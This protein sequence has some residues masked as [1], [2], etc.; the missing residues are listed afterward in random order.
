MH[1]YSHSNNK[2]LCSKAVSPKMEKSEGSNAKHL[3]PPKNLMSLVHCKKLVFNFWVLVGMNATTVPSSFIRDQWMQKVKT[4]YYSS[5]Y[6][7][8]KTNR[9]G[10]K[11]SNLSKVKNFT[12][13]WTRLKFPLDSL[14]NN[15]LSRCLKAR[16]TRWSLIIRI[17]RKHVKAADKASKNIV[18]VLPWTQ[19]WSVT[20]VD[21]TYKGRKNISFQLKA[22]VFFKGTSP[23]IQW[24]VDWRILSSWQCW[25]MWCRTQ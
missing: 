15:K 12:R 2:T 3:E 14:L 16:F 23:A 25:R 6:I 18:V 22:A 1:M 17:L 20:K 13:P 24:V 11:I 5:P 4:D 21:H 10:R 8:Q 9:M 19:P 7:G